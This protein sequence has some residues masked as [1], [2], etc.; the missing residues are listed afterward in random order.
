LRRPSV[1]RWPRQGGARPA[2][3]APRGGPWNPVGVRRGWDSGAGVGAKRSTGIQATPL[4]RCGGPG[5]K[6]LCYRLGVHMRLDPP[7]IGPPP[8]SRSRWT[9]S[10]GPSLRRGR[11]PPGRIG[12]PRRWASVRQCP[13][14]AAFYVPGGADTTDPGSGGG[15]GEVGPKKTHMLQ[16][17][18][19][20]GGLKNPPGPSPG[21]TTPQWSVAAAAPHVRRKSAV[22]N[23]QSPTAAT[24]CPSRRAAPD[25]PRH[26][27]EIISDHN[28]SRGHSD[29]AHRKKM[30]WKSV[31]H[32]SRPPPPPPNTHSLERHCPGRQIPAQGF[33][34][35]WNHKTALYS[36]PGCTQSRYLPVPGGDALF[37]RFSW[38]PWVERLRPKTT[39]VFG[40]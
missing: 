30:Q 28:R 3:G 39:H 7:P 40:V 2:A 22:V 31:C 34:S 19:Q 38:C 29:R 14:Q 5:A 26:P 9:A 27:G 11:R 13:G 37:R 35:S 4:R 8:L 1:C 18:Y 10:V 32:R 33:Q 24:G 23:P 17:A 16:L 12:S 15:G 21:P 36:F 25:A 20:K 6:C